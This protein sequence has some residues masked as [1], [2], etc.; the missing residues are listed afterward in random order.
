MDEAAQAAFTRRIQEYM[1]KAAHEAKV[2]TSWINPDPAYDGALA[3]FVE[4]I[5]S[6]GT[7]G[8]FLADFARFHAPI[9][10]LGMVNSLAQTLIK[11]G[12]PGV[13]D[14]YQGTE[15]WDLSLVDPDNRRPVDWARRAAALAEVA[16]PREGEGEAGLARRLL[17]EWPDGRIKLHV[18]ARALAARR[19]RAALFAEGAHVP[20]AAGGRHPAHVVAFARQRG[21]RAAV[22]VAPRLAWRL[23]EQ[24]AGLPVGPAWGDTWL[25]LP[26]GAGGTLVDVLTGA[27]PEVR[28]RE[29]RPALD[30]A[31][32]L[33]VLP[34][35]LLAEEA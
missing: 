2:H 14:F 20:L 11:I 15:L 4:R 27:R 21:A 28:E 25:A 19:A 12:A 7:A 23:T 10:R 30:L 3:R 33:A 31:E 1:A 5:L 16:A 24:G 17:A 26:P 13:P 18:T 22:V 29:G 9:A 8:V 32:T 6:P 34:V 35:A